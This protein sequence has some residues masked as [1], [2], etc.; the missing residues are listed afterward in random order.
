M[1]VKR[2]CSHT[3]K[4]NTK[5][6]VKTDHFNNVAISIKH[7][8]CDIVIMSAARKETHSGLQFAPFL[9]PHLHLYNCQWEM[10]LRSH[11]FQEDPWLNGGPIRL[12][13]PNSS[14]PA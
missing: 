7:T 2:W 1:H 10:Q 8:V 9:I 6:S 3:D 14:Y 13:H 12:P 5:S 11:Q 4:G